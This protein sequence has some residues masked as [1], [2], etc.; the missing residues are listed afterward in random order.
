MKGEEGQEQRDEEGEKDEESRGPPE[1]PNSRD[2]LAGIRQLVVLISSVIARTYSTKVFSIKW[3]AIRNK[4]DHLSS[5][6][7]T[8]SGFNNSSENPR[9]SDLIPAVTSTLHY[10]E[11]LARSC[12]EL[13]YSGKLLMQS[14][15]DVLSGKL[16]LHRR[17]LDEVYKA[18]ILPHNYAIIVS[19]PPPGSSRQDMN[20]FVRDLF[21]RLQI[22]NQEIKNQALLALSEILEEDEKYARVIS[23]TGDMDYLVRLLDSEDPSVK[24]KTTIVVSSI[25]GFEACKSQLIEAM[26]IPPLIRVLETGG[27]LAKESSATSLYKL[28]L[29]SENVWSLTAHGGVTALLKACRQSNGAVTAPSA[30]VL[31]NLASVDE[32]RR[33][34]AEEGVIPVMVNLLR[35]GHEA[36]KIYASEFLQLMAGTD[37]NNREEI[38]RGGGIQALVSL[39]ETSSSLKA[40]DSGFRAIQ[41]FCSSPKYACPLI[42]SG[43]LH[44]VLVFLK[45][46]E[47][48]GQEPALKAL[49]KISMIS[50]ETK[51]A[52]G[53]AGLMA[54]L[55][56]LLDAKS[57]VVKETAAET[58]SSLLMLSKNRKKFLMEDYNVSKLLQ[59][60]DPEDEKLMFKKFL[61]SALVSITRSNSGRKK[62][63]SSE[64][65]QY[66]QKLAE[67]EVIEAKRV[68]RKLSG[69]KL[70]SILS[71]KWRA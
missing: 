42:G 40:R 52:I 51:K 48:S 21:T 50:D 14:D 13:S 11:D 9:F 7:A 38:V 15:L 37:E 22:G 33:F 47:F 43:F 3:Q 46:G 66:L 55:V 49:L 23:E 12:T 62:I 44:Q 36:A 8:A 18:G 10:C 41:T 39:L 1:N 25:A 69:N 71:G 20:F 64:S 6:L 67:T 68:I 4:L 2:P 24:E 27:A 28:T 63:A 53:D 61:L 57:P 60:L 70:M 59:L 58:L 56:K 16:D 54:E 30:A 29:N 34:M 35:S 45:S 17:H 5:G 65:L 32:I 31:R 26:A 19:R